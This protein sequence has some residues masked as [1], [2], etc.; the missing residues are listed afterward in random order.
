MLR[1]R[2]VT[3]A[4]FTK[5]AGHIGHAKDLNAP[6]IRKIKVVGYAAV[7]R[8]RQ[9]ARRPPRDVQPAAVGSAKPAKPLR[10]ILQA[11]RRSRR[12]ARRPA[13]TQSAAPP[14][15]ANKA[16]PIDI[17]SFPR[18]RLALLR[19]GGSTLLGPALGDVVRPPIRRVLTVLQAVA[20]ARKV[21]RLRYRAKINKR[22]GGP[23]IPVTP[24]RP[25]AALRVLSQ[26]VR[27]S[28]MGARRPAGIPS[29]PPPTQS[30]LT[31]KLLIVT[32]RRAQRDYRRRGGAVLLGPALGDVKR[33]PV[34]RPKTVL[35]AVESARRIRRPAPETRLSPPRQV[36][37]TPLPPSP[38]VR[39][40]IVCSQAV[41]RGKRRRIVTRTVLRDPV[42]ARKMPVLRIR[43]LT[44][45]VQR[46]RLARSG[47]SVI[48]RA[49]GRRSAQSALTGFSLQIT[50]GLLTT[51][52]SQT[53]AL[54]G[55][56]MSISLGVLQP[57][58]NQVYV[59]AHDIIPYTSR[60]LIIPYTSRTIKVERVI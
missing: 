58:L 23:T 28:K 19:R 52:Q 50:A 41:E 2:R 3:R 45:S 56:A 35:Q 38:P 11:V 60:K 39:P 37:S 30:L 55:F 49:P 14:A 51:A 53:Q 34:R 12:G 54:S 24:S 32:N 1:R 36:T 17:M 7:R 25:I 48:L 31:R 18:E 5:L 9:G 44:Q 20:T 57:G 29:V 16:R 6:P 42:R 59:K 26:A 40:L 13:G 47:R 4:G 8:A 33:A 15:V 43:V 27:R 10:V 21:R 22:A 46:A